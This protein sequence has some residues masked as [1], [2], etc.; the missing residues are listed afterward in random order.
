MVGVAGKK[1]VTESF[2]WFFTHKIAYYLVAIATLFVSCFMIFIEG[3]IFFGSFDEYLYE[4]P[5]TFFQLFFQIWI[6]VCVVYRINSRRFPSLQKTLLR[7]VNYTFS[8]WW[9]FMWLLLLQWATIPLLR[10]PY[11]YSESVDLTLFLLVKLIIFL[12]VLINFFLIPQLTEDHYSISRLFVCSLR[13]VIKNI[14][15][16][17]VFF[18]TLFFLWVF[19]ALSLG[20]ILWFLQGLLEKFINYQWVEAFFKLF[21]FYVS[22]FI[23][24]TLI[25][26]AQSKVY[27]SGKSVHKK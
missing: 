7:A 9:L 5:R 26:I 2:S 15:G 18:I 6:V 12:Q 4:I 27:L 8:A 1:L 11:C 3:R 24:I 17:L 23:L 13:Q 10:Q 16:L 20:L 21:W 22:G 19:V 25:G 14:V